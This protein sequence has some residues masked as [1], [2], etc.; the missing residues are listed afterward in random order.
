MKIKMFFS[1]SLCIQCLIMLY[2]FLSIYNCLHSKKIMYQ[3]I[4][5]GLYIVYLV[6]E[7]KGLN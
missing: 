7:K 4:L 2:I 1:K 6:K 5:T 3:F